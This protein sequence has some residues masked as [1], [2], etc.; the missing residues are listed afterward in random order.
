MPDTTGDT[1]FVVLGIR[2]ALKER[3]MDLLRNT[4]RPAI[5]SKHACIGCNW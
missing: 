2:I 5:S 3:A 4:A 1:N